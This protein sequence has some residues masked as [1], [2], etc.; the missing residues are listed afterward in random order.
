M[1]K[2]DS[3]PVAP[4]PEPNQILIPITKATSRTPYPDSREKGHYYTL[5]PPS[6]APYLA[7]FEV[8]PQSRSIIMRAT[9]STPVVSLVKSDRRQKTHLIIS[10]PKTQTSVYPD[11]K[12]KERSKGHSGTLIS[13]IQ[14]SDHA[15]S[16]NKAQSYSTIL[17]QLTENLMHQSATRELRQKGRSISVP[18]NHVPI[19]PAAKGAAPGSVINPLSLRG[20]LRNPGTGTVTPVRLVTAAQPKVK[21]QTAPSVVINVALQPNPSAYALPVTSSAEPQPATLNDEPPQTVPT[22][23]NRFIS[24]IF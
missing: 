7:R 4:K 20:H 19:L 9:T 8:K 15:V 11:S 2:S 5:N 6:Q 23:V 24:P 10:K 12:R 14:N 1:V 18:T 16:S 22:S 13:R 3:F 21:G 17:R